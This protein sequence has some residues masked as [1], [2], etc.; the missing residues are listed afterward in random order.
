MAKPRIAVL[1]GGVSSEHEVSLRS[2]F[3]IVQN[4][5]ESAECITVGI[6]K[7]GRWLLYPGDPAL[8]PSGEWEHHPDCVPTGISPDRQVHGI[9]NL[10]Q[11]GSFSTIK[12][13]AVFPALHGKNGEDGTVQGLCALAGIP[14][15]GCDTLASAV[16]MDK[17][18]T[19]VILE[20]IG[21]AV[22]PWELVH[23][24]EIED[25]DAVRARL[26]AKLGYPMFVKPAGSGSSIGVTRVNSADD[27]RDALALA[28]AHGRKILVEKLI[29]GREV[30]CAV[31]GNDAPRAGEVG[32]IRAVDGF[33]DYES[34][35]LTD[36]SELL[37][38]AP[39]PREAYQN[40]RAIA[41]RA[42]RAL[43]CCGM[44]RVDFFYCEDSG[45]IVLNEVNTIPGFTSISMY[46]KLMI[47][48]GMSYPELIGALI[49]CAVERAEN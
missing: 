1:F 23:A 32:E 49:D 8:I 12:I 22:A 25:Y 45:D 41:L 7:K 26:E 40:I 43:G 18:V 16:C 34:K 31:L 37:V 6:T 20:S 24:A 9:V 21:V 13:D 48:A 29:R 36:T 42:Y 47:E 35:Y 38:P 28:Q 2:A 11:D 44:A 4:M 5:P 3:S 17:T 30:E 19:K 10:L 39:L 14:C 33:Y 15:V 27:L 46:P